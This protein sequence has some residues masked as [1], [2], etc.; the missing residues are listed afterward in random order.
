LETPV[1]LRSRRVRDDN[2]EPDVSPS[3]ATVP[4][5][6]VSSPSAVVTLLLLAL[7]P[8]D[9]PPGRFRDEDGSPEGSGDETSASDMERGVAVWVGEEYALR[10]DNLQA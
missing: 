8:S 2:S 7:G 1:W 9:K 4:T 10:H 3:H 6:N 5:P